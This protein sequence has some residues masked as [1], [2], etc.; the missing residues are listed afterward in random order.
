MHTVLARYLLLKVTFPLNVT[1]AKGLNEKSVRFVFD[2]ANVN[3]DDTP[4]SLEME[5]NDSIGT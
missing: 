5:D 4:V 2:G 3:K 1:V